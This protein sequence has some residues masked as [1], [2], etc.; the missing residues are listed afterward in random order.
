LREPTSVPDLLDYRAQSELLD[1]I[2]SL[3]YED[4]NLSTGGEPTH[5]AGSIVSANFFSVLGASPQ[6]GRFFLEGEDQAGASRVAVI[7]DRLWKRNFAG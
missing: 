1:G 6:L 4:F 7:S 2:A 5:A 3:T